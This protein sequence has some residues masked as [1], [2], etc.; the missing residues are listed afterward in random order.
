MTTNQVSLFVKECIAHLKGNDS[1]AIAL[2]IQ[3]KAINAFKTHI[4]SLE[5]EVIEL[6]E[7][8]DE[9][10]TQLK[11]AR[12]NNGNAIDGANGR[13]KYIQGIVNAKKA[14]ETAEENLADTIKTIA[15][16]KE[17]AKI[18]AE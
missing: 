2:S 1:E 9:A 13:A 3:R 16:L 14:I 4:P 11:I 7:K 12:M 8:I 18:V 6:E 15:F 5:S 10:K 17:E